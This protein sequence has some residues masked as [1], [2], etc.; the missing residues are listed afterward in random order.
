MCYVEIREPY[1]SIATSDNYRI[2]YHFVKTPNLTC[3][4]CLE[5]SN[6]NEYWKKLNCEHKFHKKCIEHWINTSNNCPVCRS[7]INDTIEIR[8]LDM[9]IYNPNDADSQNDSS[10]VVVRM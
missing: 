7:I 8:M 2:E 5:E 10:N 4:I 1:G 3:P 9:Y 6:G